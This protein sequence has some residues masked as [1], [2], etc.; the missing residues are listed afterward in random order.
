MPQ[1]KL[2]LRL[3]Q[4]G[5]NCQ[6]LRGLRLYCEA[7]LELSAVLAIENFFGYLCLPTVVQLSFFNRIIFN[8]ALPRHFNKE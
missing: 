1:D 7:G 5:R 2:R 6:Y 4:L 3:F 8:A